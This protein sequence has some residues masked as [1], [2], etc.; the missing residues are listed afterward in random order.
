MFVATERCGD[1]VLIGTDL[2][3]TVVAIAPPKVRVLVNCASDAEVRM[4][5]E[6]VVLRAPVSL[7]RRAKD[8]IEVGEEIVIMPVCVREQSVRM[9]YYCPDTMRLNVLRSWAL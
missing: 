9:A 1:C 8:T 6:D 4:R 2:S 5:P 7:W 3:V